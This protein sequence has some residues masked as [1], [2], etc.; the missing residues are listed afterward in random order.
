MVIIPVN[1]HGTQTQN[2]SEYWQHSFKN[3]QR[4]LYSDDET[5]D[6]TTV[7]PRSFKDLEFTSHE[8][9]EYKKNKVEKKKITNN[10]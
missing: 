10:I 6:F 8:D 9:E 4:N 3:L 5:T 2:Q 7:D 1:I